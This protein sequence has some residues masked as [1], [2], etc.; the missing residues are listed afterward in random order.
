MI[1]IFKKQAEKNPTTLAPQSPDFLAPYVHTLAIE[2]TAKCNLR[3]I[4]CHKSDVFLESLPGAN[5]DMSDAMLDDAYRYCKD[6]GVKY[7]TLSVGGETTQDPNWHKR[8]AKFLDDPQ[9]ENFMVSNFARIFTEEELTTLTKFHSLQVSFDSADPAMVRHLRSKGAD[10]PKIIFNIISLRHKGR[11]V[12]RHPLIQ[13][14]C[15]VCRENIGHIA[16]LAGLV[17]ELGVHQLLLTGVMVIGTHNPKMPQTLDDIDDVEKRLFFDQVAESEKILAGTG[18]E[19]R[20]QE[21]LKALIAGVKGEVTQAQGPVTSGC[22]QP[23]MAPMVRGNGDV[24]VCCGASNHGPIG[25]VNNATLAEVLNGEKARAVRASIL[26][27]K[28][29]VNC[30]GCSFAEPITYSQLADEVYSYIKSQC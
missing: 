4:Y 10:L 22:R 26:E 19:L 15:T 24:I 13:V 9:F 17:R 1:Q 23:W 5:D 21:P 29:I 25:N 7:I 30:Q 2:P 27:G 16:K 28:P 6:H 12:G 20:L 8:I 11:E 3:C 14:N 18:V